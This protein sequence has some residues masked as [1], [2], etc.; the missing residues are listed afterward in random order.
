MG[1]PMRWMKEEGNALVVVVV[2]VKVIILELITP[3]NL[4]C[5][6]YNTIC[7]YIYIILYIQLQHITLHL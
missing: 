1:F 4:L 2:G 5:I 3:G 6:L 7:I